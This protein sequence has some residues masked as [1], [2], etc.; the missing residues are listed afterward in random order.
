MNDIDQEKNFYGYLVNKYVNIKFKKLE[1]D[2]WEG[3]RCYFS[4][5]PPHFLQRAYGQVFNVC[6]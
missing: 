1:F 5:H 3:K 6:L 2:C 4:G